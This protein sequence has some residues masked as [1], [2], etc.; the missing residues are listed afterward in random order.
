MAVRTSQPQTAAPDLTGKTSRGAWLTALAVVAHT[1]WTSAAPAVVYPLYAREWHLSPTWTTAIFAVYPLTVVLVLVA[2]GSLSDHVGG[3]LAMLWGVMASALGVLIFALAHDVLDLLAGRV[4]MG[5]GVGLSAG[6][7]AAA[8]VRLAGANA[9]GKASSA[10]LLAQSLG[11]AA[12]LLLGGALVQYA[13]QPTRLSFVV[14]FALLL[15]LIPAVWALPRDAAGG[16]GTPWR[17]RWPHVPAPVR[18]PFWFA[19]V[20]VMGAYAH[21]VMVASLGAQVA[22]ELV[23]SANALV[24]GGALSLFAITLGVVGIAARPL[25]PGLAIRWGA[26]ASLLSMGFLALAVHGHDLVCFLASTISAGLG[27]ALMVHGGLARVAAVAPEGARGGMTSAVFLLAYLFTGALA[28]A[29]GRLATWAG[30]AVAVDIGAA[31]LAG[32]YLATLLAGWLGAG[33]APA[34][35]S[36][37]PSL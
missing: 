12:A 7:S 5:L 9:A 2:F 33:R 34:A 32:L 1:L 4:F 15:A 8:L 30:L 16:A 28:L 17:P 37:D 35:L 19:A 3:R 24:N 25:A 11:L 22:H 10:T 6:P 21:G 36:P 18:R 23:R 27:Y 26:A 29:L 20:T 13:P 14:L 31:V